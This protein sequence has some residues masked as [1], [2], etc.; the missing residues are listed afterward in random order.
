MVNALE[1]AYKIN[2][3]KNTTH[4]AKNIDKVTKESLLVGPL[5]C[6]LM[7]SFWINNRL[8]TVVYKNSK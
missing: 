1:K 6:L 3:V 8:I 4:S 5:G 7:E 2:N